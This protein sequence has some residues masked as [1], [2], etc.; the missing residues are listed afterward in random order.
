MDRTQNKTPDKESTKREE[1]EDPK[2]VIWRPENLRAEIKKKWPVDVRENVGFQLQRV[3]FGKE[4]NNYRTMPSIGAGVYEIKVQD[5]D[6]K[7]FRLIYVAK[8]AEAIYVIHVITG[9]TTERTSPQDIELAKQ[10]LKQIIEERKA[11]KKKSK[12]DE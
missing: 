6:K 2:T 11:E 8:F 10:R 4:P 1:A 9:K 12:D 5:D 7:Q 3:Q